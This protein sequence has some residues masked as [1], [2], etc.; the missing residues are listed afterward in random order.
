MEE[1][2]LMLRWEMSKVAG[3]GPGLISMSPAR[4]RIRER[5]RV[6]KLEGRER[7]SVRELLRR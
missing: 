7:K 1:A 6:L 3:G 5:T 2:D 4:R